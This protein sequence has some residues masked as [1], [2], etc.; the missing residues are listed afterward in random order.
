MNIWVPCSG[1]FFFL[2]MQILGISVHRKE[3]RQTYLTT[4]RMISCLASSSDWTALFSLLSTK[5]RSCSFSNRRRTFFM[6]SQPTPWPSRTLCTTSFKNCW[7]SLNQTVS[8][9]IDRWNPT[10]PNKIHV[11]TICSIF[12][13]FCKNSLPRVV[14][15]TLRRG[16][17]SLHCRTVLDYRGLLIHKCSRCTCA[18]KKHQNNEVP[19]HHIAR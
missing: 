11:M 12:H 14:D 6:L 15:S 16:R 2:L 7:F 10:N 19:E 18:W 8:V 5:T 4:S 1:F 17:F 3:G 9:I 13:Y